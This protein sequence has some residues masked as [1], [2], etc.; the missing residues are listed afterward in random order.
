MHFRSFTSTAT[1]AW[2]LLITAAAVGQAAETRIDR[3]DPAGTPTQVAFG[4]VVLDV[5]S[6]ES[7]QQSF[8]ADVGL[9]V[10]WR[11][12]RLVLAGAGLR[13]MALHEVWNPDIHLVNQRSITKM[14]EDYVDV[15]ADGNV[16]YRQRFSGQ[17]SNAIHLRDFPFDEH[18]FHI[19]F[20]S[21]KYTE[22]EVSF[23]NE[24]LR[25]KTGLA[26]E[27]LVADWKVTSWAVSAKPRDSKM[28]SLPRAGLLFQFHAK[29]KAGFYV[30]K[31]ILPLSL[32]VFMSWIV[33]WLD[34]SRVDAQIGLAATAVLTLIA[35]RFSIENLLP[36]VSYLTRLD[37][38]LTGC[39]WLVFMAMLEVVITARMVNDDHL[40]SAR[41]VDRWSRGIF[42]VLFALLAGWS[43]FA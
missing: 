20:I 11:D 4:I 39:T 32:I 34:P 28:L 29:R 26:D 19:R 31:L 3:P 16:T 10:K 18:D 7:A 5:S 24:P 21:V 33:F 2:L 22:Q 15:D 14:I 30:L 17:F 8:T 12:P 27:F 36:P 41:R 6:V 37:Y 35:F 40:P 42:P 1:S 43:F 23:S 9:L 38:F 25:E 13:S